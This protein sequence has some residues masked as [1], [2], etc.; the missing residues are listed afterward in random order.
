MQALNKLKELHAKTTEGPW[1]LE[2]SGNIPDIDYWYLSGPLNSKPS[3]D[4]IF[5]AEAHKMVP[6]LIEALEKAIEQR[7]KLANL[8]ELPNVTYSGQAKSVKDRGDRELEQILGGG[9]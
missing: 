9:D 7:D 3:K 2:G 4:E 1:V 5:I 6:R 8:L